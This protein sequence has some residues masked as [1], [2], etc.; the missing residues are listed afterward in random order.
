[1]KQ[2]ISKLGFVLLGTA[3][4]AGCGVPGVPQPP[5]LE[6][7]QPVNDLRAVR[8]GDSVYLVW[9]VP[10]ETTDGLAVRYVGPTRICRS[11]GVP[12][13]EC[14][15]SIGEVAA[16]QP[17]GGVSQPTKSA[18]AVENYTDNL[19]PELLGDRPDAQIFYAISVLNGNG[20]SA[21]PS[22]TAQVT[23]VAALPPPSDFRAQANAEGIVLSWT[24]VPQTLQIPEMRYTYRV[25]R[26]P[27]GGN[28]DT[29]A[30]ELPLDSSSPTRLVDHSFEWEETYSYRATVVMLIHQE[31][32]PEV[33]FEAADTPSV[34]VFAHDVFPPGVPSG[35]QA[36]FS[37]T[38]QPRFIDLI[39][40]PDTDADLAG[41]N[42]FRHQGEAEP[43]K[44]NSTLD[45]TPAFRDMNVI[46][47]NNYFY[48]VSAVDVRGNESARS[49]ETSEA[50]P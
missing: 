50:V 46:S 17:A 23:A 15:N 13:N 31:G 19:P 12:M 25:Y 40:A 14:A 3:A 34:R 5:S 27:E 47:G 26:R 44:I 2:F 18:A 4:L 24:G 45:K 20:R 43:V 21:G 36:V 16:P 8:K 37:G 35:L 1:M 33:H 38:G 30:G 11:V 29:V 9:T 6:L 10:A 49:L 28:I 42:V 39:W 41:Y 7:P 48:S 22:N 32:K